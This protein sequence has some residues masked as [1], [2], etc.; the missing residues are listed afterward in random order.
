MSIER[1]QFLAGTAGIHVGL[2]GLRRFD[3]GLGA[4]GLAAQIG[5]VKLQEQLTLA[6]VVTLFYEQ[7]PNRGGTRRVCLEVANGFDFAV[8]GDQ[9]ADRSALHGRGAHPQR[10]GTREDRDKSER[11]RDR[12]DTQPGTAFAGGPSIRIVVGSCQLVIF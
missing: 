6:N 10:A 9:A 5:I 4:G 8:G 12:S 2:V 11:N 7:M 3:L 1:Q